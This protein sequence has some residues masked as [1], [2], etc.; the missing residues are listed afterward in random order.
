MPSAEIVIVMIKLCNT[1]HLKCR[2]SGNAFAASPHADQDQIHNDVGQMKLRSQSRARVPPINPST[3]ADPLLPRSSRSIHRNA[4][5]DV[6]RSAVKRTARANTRARIDQSN[7]SQS[8]QSKKTISGDD[9]C[10]RL[11]ENNINTLLRNGSIT[12]QHGPLDKIHTLRIPDEIS[13]F[14]ARFSSVKS[15]RLEFLEE[16]ITSRRPVSLDGRTPG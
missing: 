2:N 3:V 9:F 10:R 16:I 14:G 12:W 7:Q 13:V 15:A 6:I 1:P 5:A 4:K 11:G 8:N